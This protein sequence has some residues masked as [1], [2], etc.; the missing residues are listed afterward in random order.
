MRRLVL[1]TLSTAMASSAAVISTP[2]SAVP[3]CAQLGSN[4]AYG[5]VGRADVLTPTTTLVAAA[6]ANAAYCRVDFVVSERGGTANGY[7][8]GQ[9]Q[10]VTLRIGLPLSPADGGSGRTI[11]A[12]NKKVRNIGGGG[13]VGSVGAVTNATNNGY[14]GSSTDSGHTSAENPNFAVIQSTHQLNYGK[15]KDFLQDS[16]RLQYQW[17]LNL[18]KT[19]YGAKADRNY[20]DGCS[21]GGRQGLSLALKYGDDFDGFAVGAPAN[22]NSRLQLITLWPAWAN[23]WS[24]GGTLTSAKLSQANAS[25]IAACDS[26]DG[27]T[28][29]ILADPRACKFNATANICGSPTAPANNCLTAGEAQAVN[30]IWDGA[31]N[32]K[33]NMIWPGWARGTSPTLNIGACGNLGAECWAHKDT[34]FDWNT[35]AQNQFDDETQLATTTVAPYS[36]IMSTSYTKLDRN[37][38]KILSYHGGADPAIPWRQSV[39]YYNKVINEYGGLANAKDF[40]RF[41]LIPGMGHC[42]GGVAGFNPANT[43]FDTMVNWVENGVAP[44][45]LTLTSATRSRL[46]CTWPQTAIYNGSG[47]TDDAAS[48]HCG[49]NIDLTPEAFAKYQH[50]A[51]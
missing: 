8:D 37:R 1:A 21:T 45:T 30:Q 49:G 28:D 41:F 18:A 15:L 35:L 50:E 38:T 14:V 31:R 2:A 33:G 13:L 24:A 27:V 39:Y 34:T 17:A 9:V 11:G 32:D 3:T 48:Y 43:A 51:E 23:K 4:P 22:F 44:D 6:G 42:S 20:W 47:S 19:Y 25:A 12:W 16:L 26:A 36:D 5:L 29:G 10:R 7:A 40:Y 46:H